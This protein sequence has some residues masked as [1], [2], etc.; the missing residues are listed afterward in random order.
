[1]GV[2]ARKGCVEK[3]NVVST[4]HNR[5]LLCVVGAKMV[6]S[7]AAPLHSAFVGGRAELCWDSQLGQTCTQVFPH[8]TDMPYAVR[9]EV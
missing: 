4:Q 8:V 7:E 3:S 5:V 1:M 2:L 9:S 6:L